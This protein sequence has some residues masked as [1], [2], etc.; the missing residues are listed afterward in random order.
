SNRLQRCTYAQGD[1]G[2]FEASFPLPKER[3]KELFMNSAAPLGFIAKQLPDEYSTMSYVAFRTLPN[4]KMEAVLTARFSA[5]TSGTDV[6]VNTESTEL[7]WKSRDHSYAKSILMHMHCTH[8]IFE[9]DYGLA[10]SNVEPAKEESK[11]VQLVNYRMVSSRA[12]SIGDPVEF[13]IADSAVIGGRSFSKGGSAWGVVS[14]IGT[15]SQTGDIITIRLERIQATN[16]QWY[17]IK[18]EDGS[19]NVTWQGHE[20]YEKQPAGTIISGHTITVDGPWELPDFNRP[21]HAIYH[22]GET[23]SVVVG[24]SLES[25]NDT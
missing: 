9:K 8:S 3:A 12:A 23:L 13:K 17:A 5:D 18:Q 2:A 16:G 24:Q 21:L 11:S 19:D 1:N 14:N 10:A 7:V 25:G 4:L 15:T 20:T 22:I 6:Y